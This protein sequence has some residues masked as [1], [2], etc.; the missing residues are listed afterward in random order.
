MVLRLPSIVVGLYK[1]PEADVA[2]E[3]G[4]EAYQEPEADD[5]V[6]SGRKVGEAIDRVVRVD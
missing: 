3:E 2:N 6:I 4:L 5:V 1:K